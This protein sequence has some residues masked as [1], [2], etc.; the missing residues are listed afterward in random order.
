M[1]TM[2]SEL[3]ALIKDNV[4]MA[5]AIAVNVW[6]TAPHALDIDELRSLAYFGLTQAAARWRP[7]CA[8]KGYDDQAHSFFK[9]FASSRIRGAIYDAIRSSDWT[10]RTLRGKSKQLKEAGQDNGASVSEMS[11]RTGMSEKEVT[12]TMARMAAKPV[13]LQAAS[14]DY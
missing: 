8:E 10:T 5:E 9:G 4:G 2:D 1:K 11:E 7:Y 3:T 14:I 13:S 12:K 6:K